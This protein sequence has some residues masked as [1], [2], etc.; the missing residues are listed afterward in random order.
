[1]CLLHVRLWLKKNQKK[2][3]CHRVKVDTPRILQKNMSGLH[4]VFFLRL[5]HQKKLTNHKAN[6][7]GPISRA[8]VLVNQPAIV[9][10][11]KCDH[12][13]LS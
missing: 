5:E 4:Q 9:K 1:M 11:V 10:Q 7:G 8:F 12:S 2:P 6:G 13:D 3:A